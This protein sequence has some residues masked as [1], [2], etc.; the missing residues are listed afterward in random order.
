AGYQVYARGQ[1]EAVA[2]SGLDATAVRAALVSGELLPIGQDAALAKLLTA[3][4]A[5]LEALVQSLR[6]RVP[7]QI[8]Q[9]VALGVL[10]ENNAWAQSHGTRYAV[11]QG[12]MTRVS[13]TAAFSAAVAQAG[14]LP[15]LALS[16]MQ[17]GPSRALLQATREQVGERP[18]GVGVLGFA[19]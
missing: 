4:C 2:L 10:D 12:P 17:E 13:D 7:A 3:E 16:L 6:Q 15:F 1:R 8:R 5:N 14:G 11:A 18:W 19:A 9:A